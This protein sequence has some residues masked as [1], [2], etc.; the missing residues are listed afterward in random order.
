MWLYRI[1]VIKGIRMNGERRQSIDR[2]RYSRYR[3]IEIDMGYSMRNGE[4]N[5]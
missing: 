3:Y 2:Y 5:L 4:E 1:K